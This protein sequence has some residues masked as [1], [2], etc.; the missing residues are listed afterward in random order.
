MHF[1]KPGQPFVG[2][3]VCRILCR[4]LSNQIW[5]RGGGGGGER[6]WSDGAMVLG[7]LPVSGRSTIWMIHVAWQ[8]PSALAVGAGGG[9]LDIFT[10]LYLFSHLS[11]SPWETALYRLKYCFKGPLN[12]T[13]PTNIPKKTRPG[14]V[15]GS[16]GFEYVP[17]IHLRN[18]ILG[19]GLLVSMM[20]LK[21]VI[22]VS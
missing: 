15:Q 3:C 22:M 18:I 4:L 1:L 2:L 16:M 20:T 10:I 8:V 21:I 5:R 17:L 14:S 6:G 13:Q 12:P 19:I 9:C 11:P 7:K